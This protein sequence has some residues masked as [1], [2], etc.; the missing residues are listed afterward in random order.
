MVDMRHCIKMGGGAWVDEYGDPD[1]SEDWRYLSSV[2]AYHTAAPGKH[3]PPILIG[4]N[5]SDDRVHCGNGR[6]LAAKLQAIGYMET[7]YYEPATGGHA[8]GTNCTQVATFMALGLRFM[9]HAIGREPVF[10]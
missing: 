4:T 3:Y 7:Y 2:S 10:T 6:K 5:G 9:R 8:Y 1:N